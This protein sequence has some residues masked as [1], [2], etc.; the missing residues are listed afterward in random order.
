[1]NEPSWLSVCGVFAPEVR[2]VYRSICVDHDRLYIYRLMS[3]VYLFQYELVAGGLEVPSDSTA[4]SRESKEIPGAPLGLD[5]FS[6]PAA[7]PSYKYRHWALPGS[8]KIILVLLVGLNV[9]LGTAAGGRVRTVWG[10]HCTGPV[11]FPQMT[12]L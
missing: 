1:M 2:H 11:L 3:A 6:K 8:M 7:H 5:L 4:C 9:L 12:A 10:A